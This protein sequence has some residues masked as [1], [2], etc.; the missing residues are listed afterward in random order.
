MPFTSGFFAKFGVIGAAVD[1][2]SFWLALI[3]MLSLG[4]LRLRLPAHRAR[5]VRPRRRAHRPQGCRAGRNPHRDLDR[6]AVTIGVGLLP[7]PLSQAAR[8]A[9]AISEVEAPPAVVPV[10]V[11]AAN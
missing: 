8:T 3:A 6:L 9:V 5:H 10:E 1:A 4:D 2:R 11:P 7:E